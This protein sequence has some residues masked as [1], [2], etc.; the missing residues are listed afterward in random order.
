M[1][2]S[3][4]GRAIHLSPRDEIPQTRRPYLVSALSPHPSRRRLS[5]SDSR[6]RPQLRLRSA[7]LVRWALRRLGPPEAA[8]I[9]E[10]VTEG[11]V[12]RVCAPEPVAGVG[13]DPLERGVAGEAAA[14]D[15]D[16]FEQAD[17]IAE[18]EGY[19][20]HRSRLPP[21]GGSDV[22]HGPGR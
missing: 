6:A 12:L 19:R 1:Y 7:D 5:A 21:V 17:A 20:G 14:A 8:Q 15:L 13:R 18:I 3:S 4:F 10:C 2:S 16:R 22:R 9:A 11:A